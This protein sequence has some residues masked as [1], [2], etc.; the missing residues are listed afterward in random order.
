MLSSFL[1]PCPP[2]NATILAI[3]HLIYHT[4]LSEL[5]RYKLPTFLIPDKTINRYHFIKLDYINMHSSFRN[6]GMKENFECW[7]GFKVNKLINLNSIIYKSKHWSMSL[8]IN[9][10]I[11]IS[12]EF[13]QKHINLKS[14]KNLL[15]TP[16]MKF[17]KYKVV[18]LLYLNKI[19][20]AFQQNILNKNW[21]WF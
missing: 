13:S 11:Q 19:L 16:L 20:I 4:P 12:K 17:I 10:V 1:C 8:E 2:N 6:Q 18:F 9:Y 7:L 5:E 14:S 3:P 15:F 21:F